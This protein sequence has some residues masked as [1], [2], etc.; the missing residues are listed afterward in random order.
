M[1]QAAPDAMEPDGCSGRTIWGGGRGDHFAS[2]GGALRREE[3]G[4]GGEREE[5]QPD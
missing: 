3:K 4:G 1:V 2:A 5:R